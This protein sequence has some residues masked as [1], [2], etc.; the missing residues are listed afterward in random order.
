MHPAVNMDRKNRWEQS[1]ICLCVE[2]EGGNNEYCVN[3]N[4]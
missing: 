3:S 2:K 1:F 4:L